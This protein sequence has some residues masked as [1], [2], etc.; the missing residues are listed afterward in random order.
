MDKVW[1]KRAR[2]PR[3]LYFQIAKAPKRLNIHRSGRINQKQSSRYRK[4]SGKLF[5]Q[6]RLQH[7][8]GLPGNA[9][10]LNPA[11]IIEMIAHPIPAMMKYR[12][13]RMPP[14]K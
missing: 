12:N 4:V 6:L 5:G 11:D 13:G 9:L 8:S 7:F 14:Q 1:N 10:D 3:L 2:L